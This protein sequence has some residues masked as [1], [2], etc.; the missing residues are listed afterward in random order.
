[1]IYHENL[2]LWV[3]SRVWPVHGTEWTLAIW[4]TLVGGST[5][6]PG[7]W[8]QAGPRQGSFGQQI[9]SL[10]TPVGPAPGHSLII[11]TA[12]SDICT[13]RA[14]DCDNICSLVIAGQIM[15]MSLIGSHTVVTIRLLLRL[16]RSKYSACVFPFQSQKQLK[17]IFVH[18]S[19]CPQNPSELCISTIVLINHH[20]DGGG[21]KMDDVICE[22]R[23]IINSS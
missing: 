23:H 22:Q 13:I 19:V 7:K 1:M 14:Q 16:T 2:T 8:W 20:A 17:Q 12:A 15:M 4:C 3:V 9:A 5:A 11:S 21:L 10:S 18:S 6:L